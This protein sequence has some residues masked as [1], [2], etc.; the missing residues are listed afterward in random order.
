MHLLPAFLVITDISG[1]TRFMTFHSTSLLHAE[2]IITELIEAVL[3]K[4]DYPLTIAK[5]EGDAVFFYA[6]APAG[7]EA[8]AAQDISRQIGKMFTAFYAKERALIDCRHGCV[9]EACQNIGEL[10]LK[11]I[12]HTGE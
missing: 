5:L 8:A 9:C 10:K 1:Y 4:A 12:L 2:E 11:A 6:E 7:Q 3:D